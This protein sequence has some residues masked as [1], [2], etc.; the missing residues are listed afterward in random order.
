MVRKITVNSVTGISV[1]TV[2]SQT[3]S[4]SSLTA[5]GNAD[6]GYV[7]T[8]TLGANHQVPTTE[9]FEVTIAGVTNDTDFYNGTF[10]A[11]SSGS[12]TFTYPLATPFNESTG[13]FKTLGSTTASGTKTAALFTGGIVDKI[14]G[15]T[16]YV[17]NVAAQKQIVGGLQYIP[18]RHM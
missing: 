15:N 5:A 7:A 16:L 2:L 3:L 17:R 6:D 8:V 14:D 1:G 9:T 11:T 18:R 13:E 4:V 12:T 10:T